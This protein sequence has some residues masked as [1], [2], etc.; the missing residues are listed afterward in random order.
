MK[1]RHVKMYCSLFGCIYVVIIKWLRINQIVV[2]GYTFSSRLKCFR[3]ISFE[4]VSGHR[5]VLT[6]II[7][8]PNRETLMRRQTNI[9]KNKTA[10][11]FR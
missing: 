4:L 2:L 11:C 5:A 7:L 1:I 9:Q 10:I 3:F 6:S 8:Q